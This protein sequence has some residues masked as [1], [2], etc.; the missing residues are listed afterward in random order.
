MSTTTIIGGGSYDLTTTISSDQIID[1]TNSPSSTGILTIETA[2]VESSTFA[3]DG[4]S[5]VDAGFGGYVDGFKTG[6]TVT[7][8]NL[9]AIL[10]TFDGDSSATDAALFTTIISN[11]PLIGEFVGKEVL[12]LSPTG[13]VTD[14]DGFIA[15]KVFGQAVPAVVGTDL[16][17]F[18]IDLEHALFGGVPQTSTLYVTITQDAS[19]TLQAD[20]TVSSS[21]PMNSAVIQGGGSYDL[22]TTLAAGEPILFLNDPTVS[23]VLNIETS[24]VTTYPGT[25]GNTAA[26]GGHVEG[27]KSGD[28]IILHD[29]A[30]VF[31]IFDGDSSATDIAEF[32]TIFTEIGVIDQIAGT[33]VITV[34]AAGV[35]TDSDGL[36]SGT[37]L[38]NP[39]PAAIS[40]DVASFALS[41][42]N[43]LFGDGPQTS[44]LYVTLAPDASNTA[45]A[46]ATVSTDGE[47]V[48]CYLRGT[49]IVT[50]EGE[51]AIETLRPGDFVAAHSGGFRPVKWVGLQSFGAR[52]VAR[53]R[54]RL[55]VKIEASALGHH[56]PERDLYVSPG[57]SLLLDGQLVLARDLVNG[58]TI[59][60]P[61]READTHYYLLELDTHDCVIAEGVWAETYADAPGL[62]NQFHN[63]AEF[64]E[65]FPDYVQPDAL[66]LYAPR[67][68][69]GPALETRL[70]RVLARAVYT[71]GI[72][73]GY[74]EHIGETIEGWAHDIFNPAFPVTVAVFAGTEKLGETLAHY[75]RGDLE[76]AGLGAGRC[77]FSLALPST[78]SA[79][80]RAQLRVVCVADNT[81]LPFT[82]TAC[83]N[84]A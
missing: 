21:G 37:V 43:A 2:A 48:V 69:C 64:H 7:L 68:E 59:T 60:Q 56:L 19:N 17:S 33:E 11:L 49:R 53:N 63:V 51:R 47:M 18:A 73:S 77:M 75:H 10:P 22:T 82:P 41:L 26:I 45:L 55:P 74:V 70:R 52:F 15:G 67:P 31:P 27:F 28:T 44:N 12:T 8:H 3:I 76:A 65:R 46:D 84:A 36:I 38:G 54:D 6:D 39:V 50:H 23:G 66:V 40:A 5:Y 78:L 58:I 25:T 4:H 72:I 80:A 29:L 13:V 57:H 1:Y 83:S 79:A 61:M 81:E 32:S 34:S 24:A 62:R 42:D 16:T 71:S 9:A 20:A 14:D 30:T 35:V